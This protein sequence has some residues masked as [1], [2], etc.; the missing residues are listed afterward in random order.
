MPTRANALAVMA[1]APIPGMVKTRLTPPLSDLQAC[2]L[3]RAL[4]LDQ[5]DNLLGL[6]EIDLYVAFTPD[7]AAPLIESIV[8]PGFRCFAQRGANLGVRMNQVFAE[9]WRR[10]HRH[11]VLI[12][13]DLPTLQLQILR[14]AFAHLDVR[15]R[16]VV[17]GPSQDGGYYLVGT[18]RLIPEIFSGMSWSHD[19]VLAETLA[20]LRDLGIKVDL[21]AGGFDV[22][23]I[24]DVQRLHGA[25]WA[26][27]AAGK[28]TQAC[29]ELL[30][31]LP[32]L[33]RFFE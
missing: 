26:E 27:Q 17:F 16:Q 7:D 21:L 1:K 15:D 13:S 3:Y 14:Q 29:L 31:A 25:S 32:Q 11:L 24:A 30:S 6:S 19:E 2:A 4:L 8:P 33:S 22:D 10:G 20:K 23:I 9:L 12:G 18:N 5:L 28:R